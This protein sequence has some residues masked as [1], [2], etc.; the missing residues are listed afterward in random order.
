MELSKHV[1]SLTENNKIPSAKWKVVKIV[2]CKAT[3]SIS[4]LCLKAKLFNLNDLGDD[5]FLNKKPEFINKCRHQNKLLS[6]N[7]KDSM[8]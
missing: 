5:K 6:K 4:K 8:D 2:Y 3:S 1:W 7:V